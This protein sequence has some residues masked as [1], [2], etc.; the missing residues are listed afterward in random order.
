[1][2]AVWTVCGSSFRYIFQ[3]LRFGSVVLGTKHGF[4]RCVLNYGGV[5]ACG[6]SLGGQLVRAMIPSVQFLG[7][8]A[9]RVP[10]P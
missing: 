1:L 7:D 4:G 5:A 2:D 8:K 10:G 9:N 6:E 3:A